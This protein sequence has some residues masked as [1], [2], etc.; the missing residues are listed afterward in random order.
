MKIAVFT[1][2][3]PPYRGGMGNVA[4]Y[5]AEALA[6]L[7]HDVTVFTPLYKTIKTDRT[8]SATLPFAIQWLEP[9]I[10]SG[11]AAFC[12]GVTASLGNVDIAY[13]HYP[14]F[15]CAEVL[16][17]NKLFPPSGQSRRQKLIIRY[18]MDVAGHG[19]KRTLFGFHTQFVMPSVL[20]SADKV[21]FSSLDYAEHSNASWLL[22][23][24]TRKCVEIPYGVAGRIFYPDKGITKLPKNI[25]F[26]GGLDRAHYF[27]G[28]ERLL[29]AVSLLVRE[30][31][32]VSLRVVGSGD[33]M[34]DY[35][36]L[37]EQ[38]NVSEN[39]HF[40]GSC[41][42]DQLRR[43]YTAAGVT[44]LPS[45]SRAESF[46]LVLLESMACGTPIIAEDIPGVRTLVQNGR[47][48]YL[49]RRVPD[50]EAGSNQ[51]RIEALRS[52]IAS[53]LSDATKAAQMGKYAQEFVTEK[54]NW[55]VVARQLEQCF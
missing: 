4:F 49:V 22:Q 12:A 1:S 47:N 54:Y 7:G 53:V 9:I 27:K 10:Q 35:R 26:V 8:S 38:L 52:C 33:M 23:E 29:Q 17:L 41:D 51:Q 6:L 21:I 50:H 19:L 3:F 24:A 18:D 32:D 55:N 43:E 14:F 37:C 28:L 5:E 36:N 2:T 44:V 40:V 39:V 48:G 30:D 11:N 15:G 20:R 34:P 25:L 13:L 16:W 46:G 31:K 45:I 42:N